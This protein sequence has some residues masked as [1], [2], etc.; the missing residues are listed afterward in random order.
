MRTGLRRDS[1]ELRP[2][3][4]GR[5]IVDTCIRYRKQFGRFGDG[6]VHCDRSGFFGDVRKPCAGV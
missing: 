3:D 2:H 6:L 1:R 5:G 4:G